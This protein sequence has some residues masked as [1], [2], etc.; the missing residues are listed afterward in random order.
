MSAKTTIEFFCD[1]CGD[2][3][4]SEK[5]DEKLR[6][7]AGMDGEWAMEFQHDWKHFCP[8]CRRDTV[9]FFRQTPGRRTALR[10]RGSGTE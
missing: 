6:V 2:S 4:G 1:R 8:D 7:T 10:A 5:P 9:A 3:I